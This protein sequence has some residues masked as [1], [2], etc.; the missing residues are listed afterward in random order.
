[1]RKYSNGWDGWRIS[2]GGR[3]FQNLSSAGSARENNPVDQLLH[4]S[5]VADQL[6]RTTTG[7]PFAGNLR[8]AQAG[9][10]NEILERFF[11]IPQVRA[12]FAD[13]AAQAV[14]NERQ[15]GR[16]RVN[17]VREQ[18][19]ARITQLREQNRER[20]QRAIQ[21]E[22]DTRERQLERMKNRY[23]ARDAAG[24]ER[25]TARELRARISRHVKDLSRKLLRPSDKQHIP[26]Q[27][28]TAVAAM[29]DAINLESVYTVDPE[30]GRRQK[31]GAGD[32]TTR[33]EAFRQLRQA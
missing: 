31:G 1:M 10:S 7:N 13:R 4:I 14:E 16:E 11:D 22:R 24:R 28:R 18:R 23:Q 8:E 30:T 9:V 21:R 33:T 29:L 26:E 3:N 19:D 15:R 25:R 5:E 27:L 6:Y 17:R 2:T 20:V 32:P 12:T